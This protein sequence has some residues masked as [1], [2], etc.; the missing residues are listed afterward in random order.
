MEKDQKKA[1][2]IKAGLQVIQNRLG[3]R[4]K[5]KGAPTCTILPCHA[6]KVPRW[7]VRARKNFVWDETSQRNLKVGKAEARTSSNDE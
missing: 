2:V 1:G 4:D 5:F 7:N 3:D 6:I